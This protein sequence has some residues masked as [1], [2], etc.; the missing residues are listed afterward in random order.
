MK[1][2]QKLQLEYLRQRM[3]REAIESNSKSGAIVLGIL[4]LGHKQLFKL[5]TVSAEHGISMYKVYT[6]G[7]PMPF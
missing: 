1:N 3:I 5:A 4:E 2:G 7:V 6:D